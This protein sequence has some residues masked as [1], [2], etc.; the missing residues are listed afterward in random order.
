MEK[1][2]YLGFANL[3]QGQYHVA[4]RHRNHLSIRTLNAVSLSASS[5][6]QVDFTSAA[7][8]VNG[9][10]ARKD[11]NGTLVLWAGDASVKNQVDAADRSETWNNRNQSGYLESDVDMSGS[12]TAA[13]RSITWN[14]RNKVGQ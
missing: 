8:A 14:N 10:A 11:V 2:H 6:T 3:N 12:V 4:I 1:Y 13:D 7:T 9:N 5:A